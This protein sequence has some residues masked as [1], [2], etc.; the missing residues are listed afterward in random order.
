MTMTSCLTTAPATLAGNLVVGNA[1][2]ISGLALIE[3]AY[4]G[5]PV[6]YSA[7]QTASTCARAATRAAA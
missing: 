7:A 1:E 3:L 2:V 6:F 5:A 4:P